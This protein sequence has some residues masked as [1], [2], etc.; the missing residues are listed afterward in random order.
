MSYSYK[1][2]LR[3]RRLRE[4]G[5]SQEQIDDAVARSKF[6]EKLRTHYTPR[7]IPREEGETIYQWQQRIRSEELQRRRLDRPEEDQK[8]TDRFI[9]AICTLAII[10]W[11]LS[12]L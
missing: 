11:I 12:M 10:R 6:R 1:D 7:I 8:S 2:E 5:L 4:L 9:D 3:K